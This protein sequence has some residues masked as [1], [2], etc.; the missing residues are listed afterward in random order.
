MKTAPIFLLAAMTALLI[1]CGGGG[2]G[3]DTQATGESSTSATGGANSSASV[4]TAA[5]N[6]NS[7]GTAV[8]TLNNEAVNTY[9][10]MQTLLDSLKSDEA[11]FG[12]QFDRFGIDILQHLSTTDTLPSFAPRGSNKSLSVSV[13]E[14]MIDYENYLLNGDANGD[15]R[16]DSKDLDVLKSAL[17]NSDSAYDT[18]GDGVMDIKDLIY[19]CARLNTEIAYFDFYTSSGEKLPLSTRSIHEGKSVAYSGSETT[20]MVVAK[21]QNKASGFEDT[22]SDI[23]DVWYRKSGWVYS[24]STL[25]YETPA[26]ASPLRI[27]S[28]VMVRDTV[29][30]VT[31]MDVS[32]YLTGWHLSVSYV[33]TG[34]FDGFGETGIDQFS[35]FLTE[36]KTKIDSHFIKSTMGSPGN[37]AQTLTQYLYHIGSTNG[38]TN[39]VKAHNLSYAD[40]YTRDG[41]TVTI[42]RVVHAAS[43]L[44]E[45]AADQI[46]T[47]EVTADVTLNGEITLDRIGPSPKEDTFK[48]SV[49]GNSVEVKN[50]PLGEYTATMNTSCQCP[51]TLGNIIFDSPTAKANFTLS[52]ASVKGT[53]SID[54]VDASDV[55]L[56]NKRVTIE[57][58]ACADQGVDGNSLL[59][60]EE[61]DTN[62]LGEAVFENMPF[63][64]YKVS[65]DGTYVKTIHVC[66][67]GTE[68]IVLSPL[69]RL[70]INYVFP[71]LGSGTVTYKNFTLDCS[72]PLTGNDASSDAIVIGNIGYREIPTCAWVDDD[73]L[74]IRTMKKASL[75]YSGIIQ[76]DPYLGSDMTI[77]TEGIVFEAYIPSIEWQI[78]SII[79]EGSY[80]HGPVNGCF[81]N[82][83]SDTLANIKAG[84]KSEWS[85]MSKGDGASYCDFTLEPCQN[86]KCE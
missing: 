22:L 17:F 47:G 30:A 3:S 4:V 39:E 69:W 85:S 38:K 9:T 8:R 55:P 33:E 5:Y 75:S 44:Y 81:G 11:A 54:V 2:G 27:A 24:D 60:S 34:T 19:T 56:E 74:D 71:D 45:S 78:E 26:T 53:I 49:S 13:K 64:D 51:L 20:V 82:F 36:A 86:E 37:V 25:L 66:A 40:A 43:V 1:G 7:D 50:I 18:N 31:N 6:Y 32:P 77:A 84:K 72:N 79:W 70:R 48:G 65:V 58:D 23:A 21:D 42:K 62:D 29:R 83:A 52:D 12:I 14:G 61:V 73:Q 35:M 80:G 15:Y 59:M 16:V 57:Q 28:S 46:L 41:D 63:G 10:A 68:K 76:A 67:S